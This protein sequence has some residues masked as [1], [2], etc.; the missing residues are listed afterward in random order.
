MSIE[1]GTRFGQYEI[2]SKLGAGG[3]GE[4]YLARDSKLGRKVAL[5][6]LPSHFTDDLTRVRRFEQEARAASALNHPNIITIYEIGE[7]AGFHFIATEFV[8]GKTIRDHI[9]A[10][11]FTP[12]NALEV[13]IQIAGAL[14]DAHKG[15]IVHRDIKP[16][17]IMIRPNGLV[18]ILDFGLAKLTEI[19]HSNFFS[20]AETLHNIKTDPGTIVGT[21]NYMS[22]EQARGHDVDARSDIFSFGIVLYEMIT[23][24]RPFQGATKTDLILAIVSKDP[25]PISSQCED[26]PADLERIINK[27][28]RKDKSARYQTAA[29]LLL[30]LQKLKKTIESTGIKKSLETDLSSSE[31][32]TSIF[33]QQTFKTENSPS[34]A[35]LPFNNLNRDEESEFFSEGITEDIISA[36]A[37][38][39]GLYVASRGSVFQ[40][41]GRQPTVSQVGAD[42]K[43]S[44]VVEG[45]V[46]R[47]GNRLR[48]VAELVNVAD[49]YQIWSEKYD[50]TMEDIFEIQD[51]ISRSIAEALKVKLMSGRTAMTGISSSRRTGNR[52]SNIE[53]H[54][55]YLKGRF[56]WNRRTW[57][58]LRLGIEH[59][60]QAIDKDPIFAMAYVGM[61]DS[62]NLLGYYHERLPKQAYLKA[63]SAAMK[64]LEIDDMIAEAHASLGYSILFYDWD[65]PASQKEYLKAIELN[66]N[67]ASAHQ[68]YGWYFFATGELDKAVNSI[69]RAQQ[70]DPL[71]PVINGHLSLSLLHAGRL[72]EAEAELNQT[73][74]INSGFV[75]TFLVFG[76][77]SYYR[78]DYDKSIEYL[79]KTI[80]MSEEKLGMGWLGFVY[81]ISGEQEK[82]QN[83]LDRLT[84]IGESR[85]ISPLDKALIHA[86]LGNNDK[87]FECL[88]QSVS[89]RVSD[90]V[91]FKLLPWPDSMQS[92]PRYQ[93]II[94][95]IGLP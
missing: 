51:D 9:R 81:G 71:S 56:Y 26:A 20:E 48:V 83:I 67:Y 39:E 13:A 89:D 43:V 27:S 45:S 24:R 55:S 14:S 63:K 1:A 23:G 75:L 2:Q 77:L 5:K 8:E 38:V 87:S 62:Y 64:A 53:A 61:A 29:D 44:A 31:I 6:I 25:E 40:Y 57:E 17:N 78:K 69:R 66:P 11:R 74:E 41:K 30:D 12:Q 65:W 3:M 4:V 79:Q 35:V 91:R 10:S 18:K 90:L 16:E 47:F 80:E 60:S 59:F 73:L 19:D 86:G 93:E 92:D 42:L 72:D 15:G 32:K 49:G 7:S 34:V 52:S 58:S 50:R 84:K 21:T 22:P 95:L 76:M 36:L 37:K 54:Q 70:I 82:A 46:R 68:W 33:H 28:L 94:S 85:N 88:R